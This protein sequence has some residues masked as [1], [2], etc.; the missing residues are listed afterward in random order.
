MGLRLRAKVGRGFREDEGRTLTAE[1]LGY[2]ATIRQQLTAVEAHD[3][4]EQPCS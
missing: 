1:I 3:P 4:L 2:V